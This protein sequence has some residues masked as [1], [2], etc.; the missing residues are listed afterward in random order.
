MTHQTQCK[1]GLRHIRIFAHYH[2]WRSTKLQ[3]CCCCCCY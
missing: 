1:V 3:T 2:P